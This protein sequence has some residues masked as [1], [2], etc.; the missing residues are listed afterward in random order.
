[1]KVRK[2]KLS[3]GRELKREIGFEEHFEYV[4]QHLLDCFFSTFLWETGGLFEEL[5]MRAGMLRSWEYPDCGA[6]KE[7]I[8]PVQV[9]IRPHLETVGSKGARN[10]CAEK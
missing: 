8:E 3:V 4:K 7:S 6:F 5:G 1:M 2:S 9:C 10:W